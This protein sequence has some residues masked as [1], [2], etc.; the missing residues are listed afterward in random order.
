MENV[1]ITL[2][3]TTKYKG[4]LYDNRPTKTYTDIVMHDNP[5]IYIQYADSISLHNVTVKWGE[6]RPDYYTNALRA[7]NVTAIELNNFSGEAAHPDKYE[8][9]VIEEEEE[10]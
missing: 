2:N 5:G 1:D 4:G 7:E 8:A 6:N 10:L 9:V 3:K